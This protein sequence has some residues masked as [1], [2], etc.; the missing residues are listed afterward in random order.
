MTTVEAS[1][2]LV[3]GALEILQAYCTQAIEIISADKRVW[4]AVDRQ[5]VK[6][7]LALRTPANTLLTV[8]SPA[9]RYPSISDVL[10]RRTPYSASEPA[11][12]VTPPETP[13]QIP[14]QLKEPGSQATTTE[15]TNP[16][17][18]SRH[19]EGSDDGG[20]DDEDMEA[21]ISVPS[22]TPTQMQA[23]E[24][25]AA[26]SSAAHLSEHDPTGEHKAPEAQTNEALEA[27]YDK[28][29][30]AQPNEAP[31]A[32]PHEA[33]P[34]DQPSSQTDELP[35]APTPEEAPARPI[36]TMGDGPTKRRLKAQKRRVAEQTR[37]VE[38]ER[39]VDLRNTK[40]ARSISPARIMPRKRSRLQQDVRTGEEEGHNGDCEEESS[41]EEREQ[42]EEQEG[43]QEVDREAVREIDQEAGQGVEQQTV[44]EYGSGRHSP[45]DVQPKLAPI[46]SFVSSAYGFNPTS[47]SDTARDNPYSPIM[48]EELR[49]FLEQSISQSL[50]KS[51]LAQT[52]LPLRR[53][54]VRTALKVGGAEAIQ[55]LQSMLEFWRRSSAAP[56]LIGS[57]DL[58]EPGDR[59]GSIS[60]P[61]PGVAEFVKTYYEAIDDTA[62]EQIATVYRRLRLRKLQHEYIIASEEHDQP[63]ARRLG[64]KRTTAAKNFLFGQAYPSFRLISKPSAHAATKKEWRRFEDVLSKASRWWDITEILGAGSVCLIPQSVS[65]KFLEKTLAVDQLVTWCK[66][67][68]KARPGCYDFSEKC[69]SRILGPLDR[70]NVLIDGPVYAIQKLPRRLFRIEK[71]SE[72]LQAPDDLAILL[73]ESDDGRYSVTAE[74]DVGY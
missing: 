48:K 60:F 28:A 11:R 21:L 19:A 58:G 1:P 6:H 7:A 33:P 65:D 20:I 23:D 26:S 55:E 45:V 68:V 8:T 32:Q 66:M 62:G 31:E 2:E 47:S 70:T 54:M 71:E 43:D 9:S 50:A 34:P 67:V 46:S 17:T 59:I 53:Q 73:D 35:T 29:P 51:K 27:Q 41:E 40:R 14:I 3:L 44:E 37:R 12:P 13:V 63:S 18:P 56:A 10:A 15:Y 24:P 74:G 52:P 72:K 64:E 4:I 22:T 49:L 57:M 30:Q 25:A 42:E 16:T 36:M 38:A 39:R 5:A 69:L 61:R